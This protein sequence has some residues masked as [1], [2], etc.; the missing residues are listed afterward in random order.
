MTPSGERQ[1]AS[2]MVGA[3]HGGISIRDVQEVNRIREATLAEPAADP[4]RGPREP[5]GP[6]LGLHRPA[7][8]TR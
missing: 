5:G 1:L 3:F 2:C 8:A 6:D 7:G 4:V